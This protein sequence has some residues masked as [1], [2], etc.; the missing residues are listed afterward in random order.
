MPVLK[1]GMV[2]I[3]LRTFE[4]GKVWNKLSSILTR[5]VIKIREQELVHFEYGRVI[6]TFFWG[7]VSKRVFHA[8]FER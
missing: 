1:R 2:W 5:P 3:V 6:N 7:Q 4:N 8:Q